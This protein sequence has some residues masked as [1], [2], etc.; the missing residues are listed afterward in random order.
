MGGS[1]Y[2]S[3][4]RPDSRLPT[5]RFRFT[6]RQVLIAVF[7]IAACLGI[8]VGLVRKAVVVR[9]AVLSDRLYEEYFGINDENT[10]PRNV[11]VVE[12]VFSKNTWISASLYLVEAG[13]VRPMNAVTVGRTSNSLGDLPWQSMKIT[14]ALGDAETPDGHATWLGAAGFTR[15]GGN[16][17]LSTH[18][19]TASFTKATSGTMT[20][21]REYVLYVE[22]DAQP[23]V[24]FNRSVEDFA[25]TNGGNFLV[26]TGRLD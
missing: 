23:V 17:G 4:V 11:V 26:V 10:T 16:G 7:I 21:G 25:Q 8:W 12:G 24:S 20:A 9:P 15:G 22:G 13:K 6:L 14:L 2:D 1:I 3:D 18:N 19:V 5:R